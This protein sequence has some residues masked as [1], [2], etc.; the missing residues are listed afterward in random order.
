MISEKIKKSVEKACGKLS[1]PAR[2]IFV[3]YPTD[4]DNG[5]YYTNAAMVLAKAAGKNPKELAGEIVAEIEKEKPDEVERM[6]VAGPG[7][8]NF[9]LS[10]NFFAGKMAEV[11]K[12]DNWG[13]NRS[14]LGKKIMVEYTDPNPFKI[15]HIG[16]LMSNAIGEAI[17]RLL[18]FSGAEV[19]RANYQG[20]VGLHVAKAI[21]GIRKLG[22]PSDDAGKAGEAYVYG[23]KA[24]EED[25]KAK[26]E[27]KEIN[28]RV[29]EKTDEEISRI[30][31]SGKEASLKHFEEIY[32]K[33]GTKFDFYFFESQSQER[34]L[35]VVRKNVGKVF[36]KS[37][38]A[39]VFRGEKF[40][41][42]TR[43][44]VNSEGLPTYEA[45]DLGLAGLKKEKYPADE[46]V[47]V[48]GSEQ[49]DYFRVVLR[50]LEEIDKELAGK[51]KHI[52]HGMMRLPSGKM[53]SRKGNVITGESLLEDAEEMVFKKIKGEFSEEEKKKIAKVVSVGAVKYSILKQVAGG[54]IAFDFEKSV[55]FEGDSGPYL[56][57]AAVRVASLLEKAGKEGISPE[58][59]NPAPGTVSVERLVCR[60]PEVVS[61]SA[62]RLEPHHIAGY[63]VE[64][65]GTFSSYYS[66]EKIIDRKDEF[67]PYKLSVAKAVGQVMKS[68][69]WLL[70]IGVPEKM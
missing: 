57:Y 59:K 62:S 44:F 60:F 17:S 46:Y 18:E 27:I 33:L 54:D 7:F 10:R 63:L 47:V 35:E 20:D 23:N 50:A 34:G 55:S 58:T 14:L 22:F 6:E 5:D 48:T 25:E 52:T 66:S 56:Q 39:V 31:K 16:H 1:L 64:L 32:K 38:G 19:K 45:K 51:T 40:S 12:T 13:A 65:A 53:S 69:L 42:H 61:Y 68:G 29:Y 8:I 11:L 2:D 49:K 4:G 3:D 21:W 26:K 36:E 30:Y 28:A 70:G 37:D 9:Y 41:L 24:Y 15:F 43:V 67:S